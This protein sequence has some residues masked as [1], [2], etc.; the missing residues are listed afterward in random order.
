MDTNRLLS[1][2]LLL[3]EQN[4]EVPVSLRLSIVLNVF[5]VDYSVCFFKC[6]DL[7]YILLV[8]NENTDE[9]LH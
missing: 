3:L 7:S 1:E 6:V 5:V 9:A 2:V 4:P 8:R